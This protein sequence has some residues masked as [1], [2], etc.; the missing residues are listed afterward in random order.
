VAH[1]SIDGKQLTVA[2]AGDCRAVLA[3]GQGGV[4][5]AIDLSRDHNS[6]EPQEQEAAR[7]AHPGESDI[8][9]QATPTAW[10]IKGRLQPTRS[11]GDFYLKQSRF[12]THQLG[13]AYIATS[14]TGPYI[15]WKP[16]V[17]YH[18][19]SDR[20]K[21]LIMATDGLWDEMSSQEAVSIAN[22][23][24]E[25]GFDPAQALTQ[26]ARVHAA[27]Q[28]GITIGTLDALTQRMRS[29]ISSLI[30]GRY[31]LRNIHDDITVAVVV[32]AD[33]PPRQGGD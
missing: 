10:Y 7:K 11:L 5:H 24:I 13:G 9:H 21:F 30:G 4:V 33:F 1:L 14:Y 6:R 18:Q 23:A 32:I 20:D 27:G 3:S 12:N 31:Q 8:L 15:D 17:R 25:S 22:K 28:A 29:G 19:V 2:N 26:A 16:E